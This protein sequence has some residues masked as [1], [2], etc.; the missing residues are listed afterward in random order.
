MC[1]WGPLSKKYCVATKCGD[2]HAFATLCASELSREIQ[3]N[4]KYNP[5]PQG[6][7]EAPGFSCL[8]VVCDFVNV[9]LPPRE[10]G[11]SSLFT[12]SV[13]VNSPTR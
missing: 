11:G 12:D 1:V 4:I 6:S 2:V 10:Y 8:S 9:I 5:L 3:R 7:G 13:F